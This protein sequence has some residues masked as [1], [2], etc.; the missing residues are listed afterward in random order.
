MSKFIDFFSKIIEGDVSSECFSKHVNDIWRSG[1]GFVR[2]FGDVQQIKAV[3][4][5]ISSDSL[6]TTHGRMDQPS[7]ISQHLFGDEKSVSARLVYDPPATDTDHG[8]E[9]HTHPV[10]TLI[11]VT[12]GSGTY[13]FIFPDDNRGIDVD[14]FP[15]TLLF[16]PAGTIHT[17]KDVGKE[18]LETLNITHVM[19]QPSYRTDIDLERKESIPSPS[20]NFSESFFC[21]ENYYIENYK[22]HNTQLSM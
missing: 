3:L 8:I 2:S 16:F 21:K 4:F 5:D 6:I 14:L 1:Q 12:G 18:G 19:N 22:I 15:G 17:I 9:Y 20:E 10:D 13:S 11:A 7:S